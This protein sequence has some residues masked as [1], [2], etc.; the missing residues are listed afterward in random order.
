MLISLV[1]D[2]YKTAP[3][4]FTPP[5][6]ALSAT[7]SLTENHPVSSNTHSAWKARTMT[8]MEKN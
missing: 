7:T 2:H 5:T 4:P 8:A 3:S 6:T 1:K